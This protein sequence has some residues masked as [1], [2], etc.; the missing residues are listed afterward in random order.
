ML[1]AT[2]FIAGAF[3]GAIIMAILSA[4]KIIDVQVEAAELEDRVQRAIDAVT[5]NA[6]NIGRKMARIL[7]GEE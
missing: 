7:R 3:F 4:K 2:A 5:P 1:Y 6:A